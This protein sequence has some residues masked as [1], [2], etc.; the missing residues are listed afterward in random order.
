MKICN[1]II[2]PGICALMM[3]GC[4]TVPTHDVEGPADVK[5]YDRSLYE[6][7]STADSSLY[8]RLGGRPTI[9]SFVDDGIDR[10]LA[11]DR[12]AHHFEG[13]D[14]PDLKFHLTEQICQLAGGP[15]VYEG[16][17][18]ESAHFGL[19]ITAAEFNALVE[20]FQWAMRRNDVP[21][22]LENQVLALL[23]PMK[24][25]VVGL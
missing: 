9:E 21:Y 23:A 8:E 10:V 18:M 25:A 1:W 3:A 15:C 12:I 7:M 22:G 6:R 17:D 11:N 19:D 16:M 2:L 20:D 4:G 14:I 13:V 24:P 5:N